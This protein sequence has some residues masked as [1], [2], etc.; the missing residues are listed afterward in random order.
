M[1]RQN[2]SPGVRENGVCNQQLTHTQ[3]FGVPCDTTKQSVPFENVSKKA[4]T[5]RFDQDHANCDGGAVL[6]QACAQKLK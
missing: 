3:G 2:K 1:K 6:L 5:V 4:V